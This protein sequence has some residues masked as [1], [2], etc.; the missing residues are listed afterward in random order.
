ME[1]DPSLS[2][3]RLSQEVCLW[4]DWRSPNGKLKEVSCRK[5]LLKLERNGLITLPESAPSHN[6]TPRI[7]LMDLPDMAN[8]R[9][10]FSG[11]G[12]VTLEPVSGGRRNRE[13]SRGQAFPR[14]STPLFLGF[15][16]I[17]APHFSRRF[18]I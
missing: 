18:P 6:L 7:S 14:L 8:F 4:L 11:L 5:A 10:D 17:F 9:C 3:G 13:N 2:R 16:P 12:K 1:K 15:H